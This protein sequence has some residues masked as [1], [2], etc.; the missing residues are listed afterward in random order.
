[1]ST[2]SVTV[3]AFGQVRTTNIEAASPKA[4]ETRALEAVGFSIDSKR[5]QV[6]S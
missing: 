4:A 5:Q 1:V 2:Y 6:K 3:K